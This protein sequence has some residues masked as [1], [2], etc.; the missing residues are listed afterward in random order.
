MPI[1]LRNYA[2]GTQLTTTATVLITAVPSNTK[3][4]VKKLSFYNSGTVNR[5]VKLYVVPSSGSISVNNLEVEKSIAPKQTWDVITILN[6]V[7]E[8]GMTLQATVDGGIDVNAN[9]SGADVT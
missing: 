6:E 2:S 8:T 3:A 9:C 1:S 7:L 5:L 4:V